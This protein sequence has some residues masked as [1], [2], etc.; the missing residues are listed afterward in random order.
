MTTITRDFHF[1]AGHRV[2]GH[3]GK[4]KH[5]HGHT[6]TAEVEVAP[7]ASNGLDGLG[8][9]IDFGVL[10]EKVGQWIEE[11]WDHQFLLNAED[12]SL[13]RALTKEGSQVYWMHRG[14]P[15]AENIAAELFHAA[16]ELLARNGIKVVRVTIRET[17]KCRATYSMD[18][19][20]EYAKKAALKALTDACE[21]IGKQ[22]ADV[23]NQLTN[24]H[25]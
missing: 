12:T 4:C 14:N 8:R 10:K 21:N 16:N 17:A 19:E 23:L 7:I 3:E 1:D 24:T 11:N 2:L 13:G 9:V 18:I 20:M 15:T 5:A 6:Y 22:Q 25:V